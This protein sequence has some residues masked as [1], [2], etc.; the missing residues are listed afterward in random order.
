MQALALIGASGFVGRRLLEIHRQAGGGQIKTLV[1]RRLPEVSPSL[2]LACPGDLLQPDS[3]DAVLDQ[4]ETV[5]N[6]AYLGER[7]QQEHAT[8]IR[9]LAD[10]CVGNGTRRLIHVST[11]TVVGR[12][13][14]RVITE[15][16]RCRPGNAYERTKLLLEE[17]L[18]S[19]YSERLEIV[20]V[21]PTA[22]IGEGGRNLVKFVQDRL[23]SSRWTN[24]IRSCLFHHRQMNLVSVDRV[25]T[26]LLFLSGLKQPIGGQI[27]QVSDDLVWANRHYAVESI[28]RRVNGL[29][30]LVMPT[31]P[32]PLPLLDIALRATGRYH[33]ASRIYDSSKLRALGYDG[34]DVLE[35]TL[36][37]VLRRP[38]SAQ[39]Q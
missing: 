32:L 24:Y 26:A 29:A 15:Q 13:R 31:L 21:R 8:A 12:T 17:I 39:R 11:A 14:D 3:L 20:I 4:A 22:I 6:L 9:N 2:Y 19:E 27:Y 25:C 35:R 37:T 34:D 7:D 10:R 5:I 30:P 1:H 16:T 18:L 23:S 36:E 33:S 38:Q 28:Y